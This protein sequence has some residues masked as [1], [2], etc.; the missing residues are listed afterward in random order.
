MLVTLHGPLLRPSCWGWQLLPQLRKGRGKVGTKD[1]RD[2][3]KVVT[4]LNWVLANDF[5]LSY[6]TEETILYAADPY[7]VN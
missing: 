3:S 6:H 2:F 1:L 5:N 7:Y 4:A